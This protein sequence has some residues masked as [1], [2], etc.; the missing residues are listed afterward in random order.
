MIYS[1]PPLK[2][3]DRNVKKGHG[4]K[5]KNKFGEMVSLKTRPTRHGKSYTD[6]PSPEIIKRSYPKKTVWKAIDKARIQ[7]VSQGRAKKTKTNRQDREIAIDLFYLEEKRHQPV[8]GGTMERMEEE[9]IKK[10]PSTVT[11]GK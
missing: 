10:K 2:D 8:R 9:K 7:H 11:A 4:T 6:S 1:R 5:K 3:Q